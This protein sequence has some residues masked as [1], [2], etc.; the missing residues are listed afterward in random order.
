MTPLESF[1]TT[2]V[3]RTPTPTPTQTQTR[4]QMRMRMR[5]R[6]PIPMRASLMLYT[7]LHSR[8]AVDVMVPKAHPLD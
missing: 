1:T 3:S 4:M 2:Q 6:M 7:P 5:M 8:A